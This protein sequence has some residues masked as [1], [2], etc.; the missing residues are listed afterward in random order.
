M[1]KEFPIQTVICL[2]DSQKLP[3]GIIPFSELIAPTTKVDPQ[4]LIDPK[5]DTALLP[6]SSGTTGLPKGVCLSH[7]NLTSNLLQI[8]SMENVTQ[9]TVGLGFLPMFHIYG[10]AMFISGTMR[11]GATIVVLKKFDFDKVL[12]TIQSYK[13]N[14]AYLVNNSALTL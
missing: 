1:K 11:F 13:I 2:G 5:E 6:Y 12:K 4:V 3:P 14:R 9:N 10:L 8:F 7:Y